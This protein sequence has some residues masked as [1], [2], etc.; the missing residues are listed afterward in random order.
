MDAG[1]VGLPP[2]PP[3]KGTGVWGVGG[4]GHR[5]QGDPFVSETVSSPSPT[6]GHVPSPS[7]KVIFSQ[8]LGDPGVGSPLRVVLE[9][10][11]SSGTVGLPRAGS[12]W[13]PR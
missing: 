11:A 12:P 2:A 4:S 9:R 8:E 10:S 13:K 5:L 6:I 1:Q 7:G 3:P